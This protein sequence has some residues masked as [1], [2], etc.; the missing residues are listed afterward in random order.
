MK[1]ASPEAASGRLLELSEEVC[2]IAGSLTRLSIC[3]RAS[4]QRVCP[5]SKPNEP[6]VLLK[7]VTWLMEA[8]RKRASYIAADLLGDPAWDILL[9]LLRAELSYE[10]P[11]VS[12]TCSAAGVPASTGL[13]WLKALEQRGLVLRQGDPRDTNGTL[14]VLSPETSAALRH[15]FAEVVAAK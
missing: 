11:S 10:R 8:R 5:S 15:Y 1:D 7:R 14:I 13:R 2:R 9:E 6:H 4:L 3:L 12:S